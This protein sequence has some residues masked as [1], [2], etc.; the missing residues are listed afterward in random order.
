MNKFQEQTRIKTYHV[1]RNGKLSTHQ[2]FNFLQEAAYRH[3]VIGEFGQPD[4]AKLDLVWMLSRM[5]VFFYKEALL[6]ETVEITSWVRSI[7][8]ALS[9]RDFLL[10]CN[11]EVIA[12]ATSLWACLSIKTI[13]PI[14]IPDQMVKR[15]HQLPDEDREITTAKITAIKGLSDASKYHVKQSDVDMVKHTN[16]V[17]YVRMVM[18]S[19][20]SE[21]NLKQIEVNYLKQS[22]LAD[23]LMVKTQ[24]LDDTTHLHEIV[25]KDE[26]VVCRLKSKWS[27]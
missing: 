13:K 1:D 3:S 2:L 18:D 17:A 11:N 16:N 22:F 19:I 25:N 26:V 8:G 23:N 20:N 12:K 5:N 7:V 9:E 6:G 15:M 10:T 14:H 21:R 24:I 27:S 4:L